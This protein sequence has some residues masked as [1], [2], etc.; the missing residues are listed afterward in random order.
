MSSL[1]IA[2]DT[3]GTVTLQAP[4]TAG[5]TVLTLPSTSGN[6]I[7][8]TG[9]VSPAIAGN[10][11]TADGTNW[12][13]AAPSSI[14]LLGTINTTSGAT[15]TLS[16]LNLTPYK[17]IQCFIVGISG[18][19]SGPSFYLVDPSAVNLTLSTLST[20]ATNRAS[21]IV[22]I[23]LGTGVL[24]ANV[25]GNSSTTPPTAYTNFGTANG[26]AAGQCTYSTA[27]T[28]ITFTMSS[29]TFDA[30]SIVIYGIR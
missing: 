7:T 10:V 17:Q 8:S 23:D 15:A 22:T 4:A 5:S 20:T 28:S 9:G 29:G 6:I 13:S 14:T 27:S 26:I 21:G 25:V 1:V 18:T 16:G 2:G 24:F 11:L 30:G 3:S 12:V 19:A